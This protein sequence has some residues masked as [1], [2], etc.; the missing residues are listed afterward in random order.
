MNLCVG[1]VSRRVVEVAAELNVP[2][3]VASR[4]QVDIGG[5]YIGMDAAELVRVVRERSSVTDVIRDH[6]GPLQGGKNDDGTETFDADIEA[7]FDGLHIDVACLPEVVQLSALETLLFKYRDICKERDINIE[8]GGEHDDQS[9]LNA[10][11]ATTLACGVH[12]EYAVVDTGAFVWADRQ[13]GN[14]RSPEAVAEIVRTYHEQKILTKAHNMDWLGRRDRYTG[15]LDLF[16][17][18]PEIGRVETDAWLHVM[19]TSDADRALSYAFGTEWWRR[20]FNTDEGTYDDRARC[21]LRYVMEE[22][23]IKEITGGYA[24][25]DKF[26]R[27]RIADALLAG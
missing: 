27:N 25:E 15:M 2:Q 20:W 1:A 26:I 8:V 18:A 4:R 14:V 3:I 17:V 11:V 24:H 9:L 23:Y 7:G 19:S 6:G 5:G 16:N 12:P 22:P 13:S 21:A 10:I